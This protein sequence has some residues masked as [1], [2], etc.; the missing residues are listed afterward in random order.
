MR[1][2][3]AC[4]LILLLLISVA[5]ATSARSQSDWTNLKV[6]ISQPVAIKTKDGETS[7]GLLVFANESELK[8]D[9]ANDEGLANQERSFRREEV[10]K[11][12]RARFRFG[13]TKMGRGALIGAGAGLGAGFVTAAVMA[14]SGSSDPPHGF[15]LFPL[16]GAGLGAI[17]GATKAKGHKKQKLIYQI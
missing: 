13:E 1:R 11:V 6:F 2:V 5:R 14:S 16:V 9:L 15:G 10:T 17:I 4:C 12:W 8:L 7:F 3:T